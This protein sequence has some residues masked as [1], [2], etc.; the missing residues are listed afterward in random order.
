MFYVK[1]IRKLLEAC[2][3]PYQVPMMKRFRKNILR[4]LHAWKV[5][6]NNPFTA[7]VTLYCQA[8]PFYT[9]EN[10][11]KPTETYGFLMFSGV[12]NREYRSVM[13]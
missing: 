5:V 3:A 1:V 8:F 2:L 12:I 6:H 9:P 10:I 7:F 4:L 13:G 11:R